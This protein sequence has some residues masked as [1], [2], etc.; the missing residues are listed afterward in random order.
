MLN[1]VA[2]DK[3]M[4]KT[5]GNT[6]LKV[7][8][9]GGYTT[10]RWYY[11]ANGAIAPYSKFIALGVKD[12]FLTA[13]VD[14]WQFYD[15]GSTSVNLSKEEAIAIALDA[16]KAHFWSVKLD[17]DT[18]ATENF[19][20]SN[21]RWASLIFDCS[22]GVEKTRSEDPLMLYPVW[23]VGIALNKWY[24]YMY[25]IEVHIWADTG[26][27]RS[28]QEA[29]STMLPS[30]GVPTAG[31]AGSASISEASLS[32]PVLIALPTATVIIGA[33][34]VWL[35]RQKQI[36][37]NVRRKLFSKK[38]IGVFLCV[39]LSSV[40]FLSQ[41]AAVNATTRGA[42]VWGSES[43]GAYGYP[44]NNSSWRK[45]PNEIYQQQLAA[46]NISSYF[47]DN[48]YTGNNGINHQGSR[49]PGSSAGQILGDI[50]T[51]QYYNDYVAVVDFDHGV[52]GYP[53]NAPPGEEHYMF[54]DNT[55]TVIGTQENHY[56]DW[57]HGVYD[58]SIYQL[59]QQRKIIFAFI[60]ACQSADTTR[61]GQ[62]LIYDQW[63]PSPRAIG[64]PFAWT[65]G[66]YVVD[67][68]TTQGFNIAQH[69]SDDGYSDPDWCPQVYIGFPY[70]SASL[71]QGIPFGGEGGNPY[72]Y[73]VYSFFYHALYY[74]VSVN[75]ALDS[76]S[77]QFMGSSFGDSPLRNGFPAYWWNMGTQEDCT[78]TVYGNG[79]I[80][81]KQFTPPPD[82]PGTPTISGPT[83]GNPSTS[84]QFSAFA[85]DPY[86]HAVQYRFDWGDG[87]PYTTTYPRPDGTPGTASHSWSSGGVYGVR[88]Q[89]RCANSDW[90]GWSSLHYINIG[91]QQYQLTMLA[92]N[93]YQYQG[94]VPLYID[95][96]YV[97]TTGYTYTLA[98]GYHQ[99][100][101]PNEV[102]ELPYAYHYFQG[103]SFS[104]SNPATLPLLSNRTETAYYYSYYF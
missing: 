98:G 29:W 80:H 76:A 33:S 38:T 21:V 90:G 70:G 10:F 71:E 7:T 18:L 6:V 20:K 101:V 54:E 74:D 69:M 9:S 36:G 37:F 34:T 77:W 63:V 35:S 91:N 68:S 12:G 42:A 100:Y 13:F 39:L 86:A 85:G 104:G 65:H 75:N 72:Y 102:S 15:V 67:K 26:E 40:V 27:V 28:I 4:T 53:I 55:G 103:Y 57:N 92:E 49:N 22:L 48:G 5:S 89:A 61:L 14:N 23:R 73:W 16:A 52:G 25:G 17:A 93:Q 43:T 94:Y 50:G 30:E 79:R 44:P 2:A 45:S 88:V 66:R 83:M 87:T 82:A 47:G 56:T 24:G 41:V 59:T 99:I 58:Q 31:S 11:T 46:G 96:D 84:Y 3:N 1:D 95:G 62:G 32:L 60:S 51:L 78:M 19:N 81:L 97:G 8:A 64:M